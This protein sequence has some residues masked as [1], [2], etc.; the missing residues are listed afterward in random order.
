VIE[1]IWNI[2]G[3]LCMIPRR[4]NEREITPEMIFAASYREKLKLLKEHQ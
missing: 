2:G 1:H 4:F 3:G